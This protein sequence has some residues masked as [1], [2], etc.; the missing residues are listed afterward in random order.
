[1]AAFIAAFLLPLISGALAQLVPVWLYP[2][3][4]TERRDRLRAALAAGGRLRASCFLA[5]GILLAFGW[6]EGGLLA[7]VGGVFGLWPSI[8]YLLSKKNTNKT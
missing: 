3:R 4:R 2:G 7:F 1:V 8:R 6:S 5:A